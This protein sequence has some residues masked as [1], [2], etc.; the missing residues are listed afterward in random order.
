MARAVVD[1]EELRRFAQD[2]KRF[3]N[4]LHTHMSS[5]HGRL[6]DLGHSWR[7][8]EH[9]KFAE[10]FDKTLKVLARFVE[11]SDQHIPFLLRKAQRVDE[12]LEQ[13]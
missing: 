2:L 6:L 7:D 11:A 5:L 1:P 4:E 13:R 8:Q 3:N 12:Y 10:E 9:R